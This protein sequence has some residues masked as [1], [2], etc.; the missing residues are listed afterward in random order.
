M[1]SLRV[2]CSGVQVNGR[3][4]E[5]SCFYFYWTCCS[6]PVPARFIF[7]QWLNATIFVVVVVVS[8]QTPVK[9][10]A[11]AT[12]TVAAWLFCLSAQ[13]G[14]KLTEK[15]E[16][17]EKMTKV[18]EYSFLL[19]F[20]SSLLVSSS[21]VFL[22]IEVVCRSSCR[23]FVILILFLL[24][25]QFTIFLSDWLTAWQHTGWKKDWKEKE[26]RSYSVAMGMKELQNWK[27]I[28]NSTLLV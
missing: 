7:C 22:M 20:S 25:L 1:S 15:E 8:T 12:V 10:Q 17:N 13:I 16:Q 9:S 11:T 19:A 28:K 4:G 27:R 2:Y 3:K 24:M 26:K 18:R 14:F 23:N 5:K 21:L 6:L